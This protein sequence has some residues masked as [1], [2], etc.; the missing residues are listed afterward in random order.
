MF[1]I[2]IQFRGFTRTSP[3]HGLVASALAVKRRCRDFL[4]E[5]GDFYSAL[6]RE[7]TQKF[8]ADSRIVLIIKTLSNDVIIL[9]YDF[10]APK[11]SDFLQSLFVF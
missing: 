2:L 9:I 6:L 10:S 8:V 5:T 7:N 1:G 3:K 4:E 11:R